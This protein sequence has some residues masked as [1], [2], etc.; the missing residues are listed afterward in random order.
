MN[1]YDIIKSF[2]R[3]NTVD[4]QPP[5][6]SATDEET[7]KKKQ[8]LN[9]ALAEIFCEQW[10]FRKDSTTFQTVAGQS[11]YDMPAG[12]IEKQGVR[13]EGVTYPLTNEKSPYNLATSSGLPNRYYV[14]GSKLVLYPTPTDVRTVTVHYLNLMSGLSA[15]GIPQIGLTLETD[16]PNIP[17]T[18]HDL[19]VSKAELAYIRDKARKNQPIAAANVQKRINQLIDLDRGTL[20]ASPIIT[21]G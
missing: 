16:V 15:E 2:C 10:N 6:F 18:F 4:E 1:F 17:A 21:L 20:E 19:I 3:T 9:N 5:S 12:I 14:Q 7:L 13:V 8:M 11:I